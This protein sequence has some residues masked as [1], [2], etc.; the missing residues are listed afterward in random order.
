MPL[1]CWH[2]L[3]DHFTSATS[4]E[5]L[6]ITDRT[7][8]SLGMYVTNLALYTFNPFLM[9]LFVVTEQSLFSAITLAISLRQRKQPRLDEDK[10]AF[11][12]GA[13]ALNCYIMR[14]LME[15]ALV[16]GSIASTYLKQ[17]STNTRALAL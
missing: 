7:F 10:W 14:R 8:D 3:V 15:K 4:D 12:S 5:S 16:D 17:A 11:V 13:L 6:A 1:K 9:K 2:L